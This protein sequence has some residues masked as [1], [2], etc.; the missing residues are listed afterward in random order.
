[1]GGTAV[2]RLVEAVAHVVRLRIAQGPV[3]GAQ[4]DA[5]EE[6]LLPGCDAEASSGCR[7]KI[8]R[9]RARND[10]HLLDDVGLRPEGL[11]HAIAE[12]LGL[13]A[14]VDG[15]GEVANHGRHRRGGVVRL[16]GRHLLADARIAR[17]Q[18]TDVGYRLHEHQEA[19]KPHPERQ[20]RP[21]LTEAAPSQQ[22]WMRKAAL[23]DLHPGAVPADVDLP[24][25]EGIGVDAS[26]AA[27]GVARNE[28][29]AKG[30]D[31]VLEIS[32]AEALP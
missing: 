30:F 12:I 14:V 7:R 19:V 26:L 28:R 6:V 24:S 8:L 18:E 20:P 23:G 11:P 9:R 13:V 15:D 22:L 4:G 29:S 21:L 3:E 16:E 32:F 31:H 25:G 17:P 2:E 5:H 27:V 1:V 10:G